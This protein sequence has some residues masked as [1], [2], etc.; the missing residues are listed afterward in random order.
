MK[1][2]LLF[3]PDWLPSE[4]YLSLPSLT[5]VLRRA[6]HEVIQKDINVEMYEMMFSNSFLRHVQK[7]IEHELSLLQQVSKT[8]SLSKDDQA[9]MEQLAG[10]TKECIAQLI[11]DAE[12][13]KAILRRNDFYDIH[14][15]EW[16]TDCI[17]RTMTVVSLGYYP[18]RICF[19]PFETDLMYQSFISSELLKAVGD[20]QVNVYRDIYR[21]LVD[22]VVEAEKPGVIGISV[23]QKRQIIPAFTFC[24]MIKER[25]PD[26]HITLGG[27]IITR[28]RDILVKKPEL[29]QWF[30]TAIL[31]EG[32]SALLELVDVLD[33]K[34][35]NLSQVPNLIHKDEKGI[36]FNSGISS[37]DLA[38][39]PPPDFDGLPLEKYFVPELVL[40]YLASRGCYWGRCTFCD[41]SQG[42]TGGFRTK[43]VDQVIEEIK[44]LKKKYKNR[45]FHFT[46]ESYPSALFK[47]L[48][49]KLIEEKVDIAWTTHL[50]FE[51]NLTGEDVWNDAA[52]SGCKYLH[53]G[54]E[55]GNERVLKLMGK[56]TDLETIKAILRRSAEAGIWNHCMGFFGFPGETSEEA[57]DTIRFLHENGEYIHSVGFMT[58]VLGKHS[59]VSMEPER[60]GIS[61]Y[62]NPEWDLAMDYYFTVNKGLGVSEALEV[63]E[64]FERKHDEKWDLRTYVREYIFLYIDYFKTNT[65]NQLLTKERIIGHR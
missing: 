3:P 20:E 46:D 49:R 27:N 45:H 30:D 12:R 5:S 48:S 23:V 7:R 14:K 25:Y 19:P 57:E 11:A 39:L 61:V 28:I 44:F 17:H 9:L 34:G 43:R 10:C 33:N 26:I 8:Q 22:P 32:E 15:L 4:P 50:R 36:H 64:D 21:F 16:A 60:Y 53:F 40:P 62:K 47:K 1:I 54:L 18:A 59:P 37:E 41:H 38:K 31:Y 52:R 63:F 2:L 42:Y 56:A 65:L 29:F 58:F 35:K 6:G 51:K 13:A 24:K 55:S